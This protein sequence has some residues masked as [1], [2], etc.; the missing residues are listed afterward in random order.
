M[1]D[2]LNKTAAA[3]RAKADRSMRLAWFMN[4]DVR[5][6]LVEMAS[7][8]FERAVQLDERQRRRDE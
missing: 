4:E 1:S 8:Y 7:Y 5:K 2:P 3:L 6:T